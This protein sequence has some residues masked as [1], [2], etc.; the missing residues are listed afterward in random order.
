[1]IHKD[2]LH[3]ALNWIKVFAFIAKSVC[4]FKI[5]QKILVTGVSPR[6]L[7][8]NLLGSSMSILGN[9]QDG[10]EKLLKKRRRTRAKYFRLNREGSK[11]ITCR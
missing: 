6:A 4:H 7:S 5:T 8:L 9:F 11:Y 10:R 2:L 1:M 3:V